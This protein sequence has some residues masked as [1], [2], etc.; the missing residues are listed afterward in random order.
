MTDQLTIR[1]LRRKWKPHKE[2]LGAQGG[3]H[4]HPTPIRFHR[5]CSWL[6]EIENL[7]DAEDNDRTLIYQWI[8][9]N[10]LYGQ[11]DEKRQ[12]PKQDKTSWQDFLDQIVSLDESK[13]LESMLVENKKLVEA[14]LDDEYLSKLFWRNPN[15]GTARQARRAKFASRTWYLEEKWT[16]ILDRV[17]DRIYQIRCQLIHGAATYNGKLNRRSLKRCVMM[18]EHVMISVLQVWID[19]GADQDWGPMCYPPQG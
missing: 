11:W 4:G 18:L 17:M 8:A 9:F 19:H 12:E 10:A 2:R 15:Q 1:D 5:A 7:T 13:Y 14:I 6:A 3:E 16:L